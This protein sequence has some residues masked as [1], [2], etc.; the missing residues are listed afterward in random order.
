M[1]FFDSAQDVIDKGVSAAKGVVSGVAVE[2]QP[3]MKGFA[4]L[5][6]DG[7]E[8]GWH[9]RNG[10]N[11]TYC[12]TDGEV[13]DCRPFFYE[14]PCS[15]I[16]L[17]VQADNLR[18]AFFAVTG[19]GRYMRNVSLDIAR[20]V[21]IVE[22]NAEG[23]ACRIVWGL[24]DGGMPSSEF[25]SHFMIHSV[26]VEVTGGSSR[27]LYH[28]HPINVVALTSVMPL[29]ARTV[30]RA[31]WKAMT[32]CIIAFPQGVGVLPWMV[33]GGA[34]IA[35]A[36]SELMKTYDAVI[37]AQHGLFCSGADFD[38]TFGL[39]HTI[40][41]ASDIYVRARLLNGGGEFSNTISDE[42]LRAIA[43]NLGLGVNEDFLD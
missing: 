31:L 22:I 28:A 39:M 43:R 40:E 37:W 34:E 42:G 1:G 30:T 36:T 20:N 29:D 35:M 21:G 16:P 3:F 18:G 38:S 2:Q 41:K 5:C 14:N 23:D 32:E 24:K 26:R 9:E 25:P 27:V 15:W 8:Q 6:A 17:G 11:L 13:A 19:A 12:M 4:R 33:P 10:G 7:W